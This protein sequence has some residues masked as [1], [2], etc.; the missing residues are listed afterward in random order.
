[1]K[2]LIA[3][4]NLHLDCLVDTNSD[5]QSLSKQLLSREDSLKTQGLA[6]L[7]T[8]VFDKDSTIIVMNKTDL[9]PHELT[10]R[11][12]EIENVPIC[13]ISCKTRTGVD[14]F[15]DRMKQLLEKM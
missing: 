3:D 9:L 2:I 8:D 12:M 5:L 6:E 10:G 1:M 13:W 4:S 11:R 15:M 14:V 7:S